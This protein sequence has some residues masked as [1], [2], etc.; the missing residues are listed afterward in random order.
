MSRSMMT[1]LEETMLHEA[2]LDGLDATDAYVVEQQMRSALLAL[3]HAQQVEISEWK[4]R[5]ELACADMRRYTRIA[6]GGA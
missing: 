1:P 4:R 6:L 5:Y 3:C 2:I